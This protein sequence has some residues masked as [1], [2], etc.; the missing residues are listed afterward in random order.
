MKPTHKS[1][2]DRAVFIG[3]TTCE[4]TVYDYW[5]HT[6]QDVGKIY[7]FS[8]NDNSGSFATITLPYT[9]DGSE[10][11]RHKMSDETYW[12]ASNKEGTNKLC[13]PA[14]SSCWYPGMH[15]IAFAWLWS[16]LYST[17]MSSCGVRVHSK[18]DYI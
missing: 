11:V 13:M 15:C 14:P 8:V 4:N 1:P 17:F 2:D 3:S 6:F 9:K 10:P 18:S 5:A 7:L 16:S 12:E